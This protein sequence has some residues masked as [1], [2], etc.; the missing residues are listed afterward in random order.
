MTVVGGGAA[1]AVV[2][3]A[4]LRDCVLWTAGTGGAAAPEAAVEFG[5]G[6]EGT[7]EVADRI[8]YIRALAVNL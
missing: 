7:P 8:R 1:A 4:A 2:E 3:A 5:A 6:A